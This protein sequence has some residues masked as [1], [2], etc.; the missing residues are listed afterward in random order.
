MKI[1]AWSKGVVVC[2]FNPYISM[3]QP[4]LTVSLKLYTY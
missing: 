1:I 2:Y 4:L 3:T